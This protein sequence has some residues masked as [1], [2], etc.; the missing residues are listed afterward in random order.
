MLAEVKTSFSFLEKQG[1]GLRTIYKLFLVFIIDFYLRYRT[2]FWRKNQKY[3]FPFKRFFVLK[4]VENSVSD[5]LIMWKT[6]KEKTTQ[7]RYFDQK[8]EKISPKRLFLNKNV[9]KTQ[10]RNSIFLKNEK[11]FSTSEK[12]NC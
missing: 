8:H 2:V 3:I 1:G 10:E 9:L 7:F 5:P 6:F 11:K 4:S 12:C